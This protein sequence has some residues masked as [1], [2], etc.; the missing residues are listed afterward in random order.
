MRMSVTAW[1]AMRAIELGLPVETA[2]NM[3]VGQLIAA[4]NRRLS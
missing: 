3:T 1:I 2:R 4:R